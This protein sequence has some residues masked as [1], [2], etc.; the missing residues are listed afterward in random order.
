MQVR[1]ATAELGWL[2]RPERLTDRCPLA[3]PVIEMLDKRATVAP[4]SPTR[5][6]ES[7]CG[8]PTP[9]SES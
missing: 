6:R 7:S 8:T 2:Q 9:S 5:Q 4:R 3:L 1:L